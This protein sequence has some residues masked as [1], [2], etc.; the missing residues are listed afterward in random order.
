MLFALC[1][2]GD[3]PVGFRGSRWSLPPS[4][5]LSSI[6]AV[7][8]YT[9][10]KDDAREVVDLAWRWNDRGQMFA[11]FSVTDRSKGSPSG[12]WDSIIRAAS[13][14][15]VYWVYA[16]ESVTAWG[17]R[18]VV[19]KSLTWAPGAQPVPLPSVTCIVDDANTDEP[20]TL[21]SL[22]ALPSGAVLL[23]QNGLFYL[24]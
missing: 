13:N 2:Q 6:V 1:V 8:T 21:L 22:V 23:S 15:D 4:P 7:N 12:G 5:T 10:W 11:F 20:C 18:T 3:D 24:A 9:E 17:A 14:G 16:R 19:V